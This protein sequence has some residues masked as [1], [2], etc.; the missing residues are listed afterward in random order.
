MS[1][2]LVVQPWYGCGRWDAGINFS[3]LRHGD[4]MFPVAR[5]F[6]SVSSLVRN[7]AAA[8]AAA[9]KSSCPEG[10]DL[11][12]HVKKTTKAPVAKKDEDYPSWLWDILEPEIQ[13]ENQKNNGTFARKQMRHANIRKIKNNNFLTNM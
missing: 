13:V 2:N 5:R 10:T 6:L 8:A 11:K 12:L 7:A 1:A 3:A 9:A 4:T